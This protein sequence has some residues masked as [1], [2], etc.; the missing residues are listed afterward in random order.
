MGV[1]FLDKTL[2]SKF[3]VIG[4]NEGHRVK[5][6]S[7]PQ[8]FTQLAGTLTMCTIMLRTLHTFT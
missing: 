7:K 8:N 5:F 2:M 1:L 4:I 6:F 3:K